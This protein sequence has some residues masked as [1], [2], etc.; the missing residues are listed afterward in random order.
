MRSSWLPTVSALHK[1]NI[2]GLREL[3]RWTGSKFVTGFPR[4]PSLRGDYECPRPQKLPYLCSCRTATKVPRDKEVD[5]RPADS[6]RRQ[7]EGQRPP[8]A[9]HLPYGGV[10]LRQETENEVRYMLE[11]E[12]E[13]TTIQ[14]Q[15]CS[16]CC[17]QRVKSLCLKMI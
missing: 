9:Q 14:S 11:A 3:L 8:E 12:Q 16:L 1:F 5:D 17:Q 10:S 2:T 7:N 13:K 4:A 15:G 6:L